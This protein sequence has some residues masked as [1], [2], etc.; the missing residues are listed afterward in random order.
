MGAR[1][2]NVSSTRGGAAHSWSV[3]VAVTHTPIGASVSSR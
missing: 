1:S 3:G 2:V